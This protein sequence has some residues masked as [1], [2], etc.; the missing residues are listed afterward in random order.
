[1]VVRRLSFIPGN[2]DPLYDYDF[3]GKSGTLVVTMNPAN[4]EMTFEF[5][6]L[7]DGTI[8]I[9]RTVTALDGR[10]GYGGFT[11]WSGGNAGDVGTSD[12]NIAGREITS[13]SKYDFNGSMDGMLF[14]NT[15]ENN[16]A[17]RSSLGTYTGDPVVPPN[18]ILPDNYHDLIGFKYDGIVYSTGANDGLLEFYLGDEVDNDGGPGTEYVRQRFKAYS[19]NGVNNTTVSQHHIFVG[20]LLDGKYDE[21]PNE[22]LTGTDPK[23]EIIR[24]LSMFEVLYDGKNGLN[25]GSGINNLN[26]S[27]TIRFFSGNGQFGAV[28]DG[29]P[30]LLIPNMAEAGGTDV[31]YFSDEDGNVIGRPISLEINNNDATNPP[32][33]H[34]INDQY[35]VDLGVSFEIAKPS[36]R[37]YGTQ[38]ERPMRLIAFELDDFG[39]TEFAITDPGYDYFTNITSI[40]NINAGAGGTADIPFLAYNGDT[41]EIESPVV[42]ERPV[43]RSVCEADGTVNVTFSVVAKYDGQE[44]TDPDPPNTDPRFLTY[45]WT[46]DGVALSNGPNYSGVNTPSLTINGV[47]SGDLGLYSLKITNDFGTTPVDVEVKEGGTR[48]SWNGTEW[49]YPPD[50]MGGTQAIADADRKMVITSDL[51]IPLN[52]E[53]EG[54]SCEVIPGRTVDIRKNG[55]LK[56]FDELNLKQADTIFDPDTGAI[57]QIIPAGRF[58]IEDD[59]SLVQ[60][61]DVSFNQNFG[62]IEMYRETAELND[63]DYVYWSS[64]VDGFSLGDVGIPAPSQS[65][66]WDQRLQNPNGTD[67]YWSLYSGVM[68]PG[69]GYIARTAQYGVREALFK[70]V[71]N[72]GRIVVPVYKTVDITDNEGV[73]LPSESRHWNLVGNPYPSAISA[74]KLLTDSDNA[75]VIEGSVNVWQS[76]ASTISSVNPDPFYEDQSYSYSSAYLTYN[77]TGP[78]IP[79]SYEGNI[80]A[81]Q[82]F[83]VQVLETAANTAE[84]VFKNTMRYTGVNKDV[85]DNTE[86][87]R[88]SQSNNSN[89]GA[90]EERQR[91]W[92]NVINEDNISSTTLVGYVAGATLSKD[93][94]YDAYANRGSSELSIY[95]LLDEGKMVIQGRPLPFDESDT[96][97]LGVQ[98][99][100]AGI[101]RIG[102]DQLD[103]SIFTNEETDI[104][105]EDTY[106]GAVH[107]LRSSPYAFDAQQGTYNDRFILK[108]NANQLSTKE[109]ARSDTFAYIKDGVFHVQSQSVIEQVQVYDLTGKLVMN[110]SPERNSL[111]IQRD[112][113]YARGAYITL[114]TLEGDITVS[115]KL[116]N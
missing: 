68:L 39:I 103:G 30:D 51:E 19:T 8:D 42:T 45:Q 32:L 89:E 78:S 12:G 93:R 83:F 100:E 40:F 37:I 23:F 92:L 26:Q 25:I 111:N 28:A 95:S 72:N 77:L 85:I 116:M 36:Q 17:W 20:D 60:T 6:E 65:Y 56:L 3:A 14:S 105:L 74:E 18:P 29:I 11:E 13:A 73:D 43:P 59:G 94:L 91:V 55:T 4:G 104:I 106:T 76:S 69:V 38:Q 113:N 52:G 66:L 70:G 49:V 88:A 22:F 48:V 63:F 1:M 107:D 27:T 46:K 110:Y 87:M 15:L 24:N 50:G 90:G 53:L 96:V 7:G 34:W 2:P 79:S 98:I 109:I 58:I 10:L 82:G 35:R 44:E 108:Y 99:P 75:N 64:P 47:A 41:F 71:P 61:K 81:G 57:D 112:F 80:A 84:M 114:I 67:G 5:D 21:S 16:A 9:S 54:C 86:F 31:Y 97:D 115:K 33:S 62:E 102:I 101:Y